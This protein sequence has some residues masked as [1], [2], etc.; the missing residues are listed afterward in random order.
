[1][2]VDDYDFELDQKLIAQTPLA[3]RTSSKLLV[4]DKVTGEIK[5][6]NF[7]NIINY[8]TTDDVLVINNSKVI[9]ARI[10][11]VK[12]D[13]G[14]NIEFLL[15]NELDAKTWN[16]LVKP[17]KRVKLGT[18]V[19][20]GNNDIIA[21]CINRLEDGIFVFELEYE[22][23][24]L[25]ILDRLGTMPL[26]PYIAQQLDD[27][28]R[29]QTVYAKT[30][31]SVAAPTAGLHFTADLLEQ[32]KSKGIEVIEVTLHVGLGT[33]RPMSVENVD[34]HIMHEEFYT[35]SKD[36]AVKLQNAKNLHKNIV[37]V[38]TTTTRVLET[39]YQTH[40][41]ICECSGYSRIFIYPGYEFKMVDKLITNFHLPKSTL[42]MLVSALSSK[43][44]IMN[45][46][47]SAIEN[48]YRFFSF[49]D[50]MFIK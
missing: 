11:G 21:T 42:L 29:Y 24:L 16:V 35:V 33:F 31:G 17:G 39:M 13:T 3:D 25:E 50:A 23:V 1:M 49:G 15:L 46:Y 4:L 10:F 6:D 7:Y 48:E 19:V 47:K 40:N 20:F 27:K 41:Q 32:I 37:S 26:P 5:H 44:I 43:D 30:S 45:A 12:E 38:G 18:R 2:R 34:D 8:L 36:S 28:D 22:G 14:A 9:P